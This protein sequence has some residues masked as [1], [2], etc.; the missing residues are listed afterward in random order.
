MSHLQL[1]TSA[2]TMSLTSS[3]ANTHGLLRINAHD[4]GD[5][6]TLLVSPKAS[7]KSNFLHYTSVYD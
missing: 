3:A 5:P 1:L 6:L 7:Q 4:F 2:T